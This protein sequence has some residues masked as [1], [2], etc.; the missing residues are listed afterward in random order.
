MENTLLEVASD[1][2][3]GRVRLVDFYKGHQEIGWTFNEKPAYL[4]D[5]GALDE[6]DPSNPFVIIPNYVRMRSNCINA[7]E[8]YQLCCMDVC[9]DLIDELE[10]NIRAPHASPDAIMSILGNKDSIYVPAGR[11][12]TKELQLKLREVAE[13]HGGQ[14]PLHGRLLAQWMHFAYPMECAYPH[15][16]GTIKPSSPGEWIAANGQPFQASAEEIARIVDAAGD[17]PSN[18]SAAVPRCDTPRRAC[19]CGRRSRSWWMRRAGTSSR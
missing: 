7:S 14:V 10:S 17:L 4:R 15:R 19:A 12:W 3:T 18:T 9:E 13:H 5:Q 8:Y 6:S 1:R 16:S 2:S 11:V